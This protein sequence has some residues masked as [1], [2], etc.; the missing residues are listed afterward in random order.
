MRLSISVGTILNKRMLDVPKTQK[1]S[2]F[3][4]SVHSVEEMRNSYA[5]VKHAQGHLL[6]SWEIN[7]LFFWGFGLHENAM[8]HR[9]R[10]PIHENLHPEFPRPPSLYEGGSNVKC[11]I[12]MITSGV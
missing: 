10:A 2:K 3:Q 9:N 8:M 7:G 12:R 4:M 11:A 5:S 6:G 1:R